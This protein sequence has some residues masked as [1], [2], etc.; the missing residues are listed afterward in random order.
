MNSELTEIIKNS[1]YNIE[2]GVFIYCKVSG[3]GNMDKHFMISQDK[4]E[5][6]VV[7]K[8]ENLDTLNLI[9]K[10]KDFY[11]L[12]A[13]NVSV[14][15]YAVGFLAAVTKEIADS[16]MNVLVIST[17]SKDYI[18]VRKEVIGQCE[19]ALIKLG[20]SKFFKDS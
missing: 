17:Y 20:F 8:Q 1:T 10:N 15:F 13:L 4:D 19:Q 5:I 14:P 7:T 11:R 16:G 18:L 6:T 9:E 3:V 2:D 12:I